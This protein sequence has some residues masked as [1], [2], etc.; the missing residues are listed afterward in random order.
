MGG[1][2]V[3]CCGRL[4]R[5]DG[6]RLCIC[7]SG[8]SWGS[9]VVG[10]GVGFAVSYIVDRGVVARESVD[11]LALLRTDGGLGMISASSELEFRCD[12]SERLEG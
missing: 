2:G 11:F 9:G 4:S 12:R 7:A 3:F 6:R 5:V 1:G 10:A 8:G